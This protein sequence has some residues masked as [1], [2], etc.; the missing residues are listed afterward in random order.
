MHEHSLLA[1]EE[2]RP[3]LITRAG[4]VLAWVRAHPKS[5]DREIMDGMGFTDMNAVRPRCTELVEQDRLVEVGERKC[6]VTRKL[7][8]VLDLSLAERGAS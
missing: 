5:T 6:P 4:A 3:K 2:E 8:R 1:Y 7:V